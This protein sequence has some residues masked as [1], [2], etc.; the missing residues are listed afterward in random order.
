MAAQPEGDASHAE[1]EV[2]TGMP[3]SATA[4]RPRGGSAEYLFAGFVGLA[5]VTVV[6][7]LRTLHALLTWR[8]IALLPLATFQDLFLIAVLAW[9]FYGLFA[10]AKRPWARNTVAVAGWTVCLGLALYTYLSAIIYLIIRR[11]LTAGLLVAA[12]NLRGIQSSID[13]VV[14]P[15]LVAALAIAPLYT[16][17]IA[18]VLAR[19]VPKALRQWRNGFHSV[20]GL[21]FSVTFLIGAQAWA[22]R[23]VPYSLESFNPQWTFVSS[24]FESHTPAVTDPIPAGY[25]DD[26]QPVGQRHAATAKPLPVAGMVAATSSKPLNVMMVILE[27]VGARRV[28][29]YGA[30]FNDTPNLD[31]LAHHAMVFSRVY[32]AEAETSAAM[33]ALLASVYPDHDWPSI[34]Q[35][36]PSLAIPGLPAVLSSHG[37]RTAFMHSGELVFDREGEFLNT[38]GFDKI[39]GEPRDYNSPREM[40]ILPKVIKWIKAAPSRPFFLVIWTHNTHHPYVTRFH[41]DYGVRD[42]NLNRYLNGVYGADEFIK[43][44]VA[45]L[46]EMGLAD[47]TLLVVTGD[48]GEAFGEHGELIHGGSVYN[49][50]VHVPLMIENPKLF[51]HEVVVD[52]LMRQIDIAPT[53]LALLGFNSPASWQGTDVLGADPPARAYLFAGTGNF[54]FGLVEGNLKYIYNFRRGQTQLYNLVTDPGEKNNLASDPAYAKMI[55][56]DHLRLEAWVSFQNRYL[57]RFENPAHAWITPGPGGH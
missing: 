25:L 33:G 7:P 39:L 40:E 49:E 26:F 3:M 53:L 19:W 35:I 1:A 2:S 46:Q 14:T 32:V 56:R 51:Q 11:P 24:A 12:D 20:I 43:R 13:A 42:P 23:Y 55:K 8:M 47:R 37:Y 21:A 15:G 41:H 29:L 36:A 28:H 34:T 38:R 18:W 50:L 4:G 48:H 31:Q 16:L 17:F 9:I 30:P 57:A 27:S 44:L 10:I 54:T 6:T 45:T 22:V 5:I 52:R